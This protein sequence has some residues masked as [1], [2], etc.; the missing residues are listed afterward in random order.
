MGKVKIEGKAVV[1]RADGTIKYDDESLKGTYGEP[2]SD[3]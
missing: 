1:R 3:L 2:E